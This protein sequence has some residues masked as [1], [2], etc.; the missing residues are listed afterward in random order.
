M[1][2]DN[3]LKKIHRGTFTGLNGLVVLWET[4]LFLLLYPVIV[5][6]LPYFAISY[7]I[8]PCLIGY[9]ELE[10]YLNYFF[11]RALVEE[12]RPWPVSAV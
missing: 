7:V 4:K 8:L 10:S 5:V 2:S 1:A 3:K 12:Y 9:N 6:I 11:A